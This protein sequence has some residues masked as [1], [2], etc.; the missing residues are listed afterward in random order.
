MLAIGFT[1]GVAVGGVVAVAAF[2]AAA[3]GY[4]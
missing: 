4:I 1:C 2:T 3:L